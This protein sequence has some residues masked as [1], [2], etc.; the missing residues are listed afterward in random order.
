M[1]YVCCVFSYQETVQM[2]IDW[3]TMCGIK[4]SIEVEL[5]IEEESA[6]C[7]AGLD[8]PIESDTASVGIPYVFPVARLFYKVIKVRG[9]SETTSDEGD[10][11]VIIRIF[12]QTRGAP[13]LEKLTLGSMKSHK[14]AITLCLDLHS[15]DCHLC[16]RPGQ[17]HAS[18]GRLCRLGLGH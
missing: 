18:V 8:E 15:E 6:I 3:A 11:E 12:K 14:K 7:I 13:A 9:I 4:F 5:R 2:A 16:H 10:A 1:I 17:S